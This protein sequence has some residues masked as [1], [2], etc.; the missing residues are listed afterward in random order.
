MMA[1]PGTGN[2]SSEQRVAALRVHL[3]QALKDYQ[4]ST[5][6]TSCWPF[7]IDAIVYLSEWLSQANPEATRPL[8][9][10]I[11]LRGT[12]NEF[13]AIVERTNVILA[14]RAALLTELT[15]ARRYS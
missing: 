11:A 15:D 8:L 9:E 12:D 2:V 5:G 6:D 14:A 4:A 1:L 10:A 7:T 13:H 3:T